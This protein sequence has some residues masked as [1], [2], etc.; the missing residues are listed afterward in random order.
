MRQ[1]YAALAAKIR[2][3]KPHR[4]AVAAAGD[5]P[6][7]QA[8][9]D[10][11]KEGI[12]LPVLCGDIERIDAEARRHNLDISPFEIIETDSDQQAISIAVS[13][14]RQGRA[15]MLMKGLI[16]TGDL[17]RAVLDKENGLRAGGVLS[18]VAVLDCPTLGRTVLLTDSAI[19]TA[20]DLKIKAQLIRNAV[21]VAHALGEPEPAVAPLAALELVNPDMPATLDAAA[22][23]VMNERGQ[24]TGCVVDGPLALDGALSAE[25]AGHKGLRSPAA[26]RADILLTHNI[27]AGNSVMKTF[28]VVAGALMGGI[29]MGAAAPIVLTSRSD[30]RESK[31]YAIAVAC[32]VSGSKE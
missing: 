11:Y 2:R 25:A 8:V 19:V 1:D 20:P 30:S 13:L 9:T 24:I 26:G 7:L 32:A 31:L 14:V 29:V 4:I 16:Q 5:A 3:D 6:V 18:H 22:L 10:A 17:L 28:T 12:A 23:R 21:A 27:E 15:D